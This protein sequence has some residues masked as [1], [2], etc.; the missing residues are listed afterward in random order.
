MRAWTLLCM[1]MGNMRMQTKYA[2]DIVGAPFEIRPQF[3]ETVFDAFIVA[4]EIWIF[5]EF[6]LI[7]G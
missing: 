4:N 6:T 1:R 3:N 5:C 7:F 2:S